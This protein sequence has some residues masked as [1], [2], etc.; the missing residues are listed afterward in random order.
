[1]NIAPQLERTQPMNAAQRE[2]VAHTEGPLLVIAGPGSGKTRS[3]ILRT[4]NILLLEKAKPSEIVLCTYTEKAANELRNRF[5]ALAK[6][7]NFAE[8]ISEL[9]VGT[10]H[11]ICNQLIAEHRHHT[12]LGNDYQQMDQFE[13]RL[14]IFEHLERMSGRDAL[15][16]FEKKWGS[17]WSIA[18][19]LQEYFD[20]FMEELIDIR[21]LLSSS[22]PFLYYLAKAYNAY[23]TFLIRENRVSFA[24]SQRT[25]YDL[26]NNP[27]IAPKIMQKIQY[28][29]VDEYQDTNYIQEQII[30][31]L[32]SA[33]D[34][35]CVIGDE[36]QSLYRF[37]GAT[38]RNILD[39]TDKSPHCATLPLFTNY[40]SHAKIVHRYDQWMA[41]GNWKSAPNEPI[42]RTEKRIIPRPDTTYIDYPAVISIL[43]EKVEDEAQQFAKLV[44]FLYEQ[45]II[46][47]YSQVALLLW[48]VKTEYSGVYIEALHNQNIPVFCPRARMYFKQ[49]EISLLIGCFAFL[50]NYKGD[51]EDNSLLNERFSQFIKKDCLKLLYA[52]TDNYAP[53]HPLLLT[54]QEIR[55][56]ILQQAEDDASPSISLEDCFYQLLATEPFITNGHNGAEHDKE[57]NNGY[58]EHIMHSRSIFSKFLHTFQ[59]AYHHI[60]LN[61]ETI[62][63]IRTDFFTIFLQFLEDSGINEY[64]DKEQPFLQG[65]VQIMTIHQAKGLEFPIVVVGSLGERQSGAH[66][67][68]R[69][70][71]TFYRRKPEPEARI[72]GFDIMRLYYVAFSRAEKLLVLTGN[73]AKPPKSSF[74]T[75][76][77]GLPQWPYIQY[78]L[79]TIS[80]S[81]IKEQTLIKGRYSFTGHIQMYETCPRQYE[82]YQEYKFHPSKQKETFL[83]LLVHQT[84][85]EL[86][87]QAIAGKLAS[88]NEQKIWSILEQV[89]KYLLYTRKAPTDPMLPEKAF[90]QIH[91]YFKQNSREIQ[92][93]IETEVPISIEKDGYILTGRID[94]LMKRNNQL[95]LLDFKVGPRPKPDDERLIDYEATIMHLCSR[96]RKTLSTTA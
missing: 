3:L 66:K 25:A 56:Q 35:V 62:N 73:R 88:L 10:I 75:M 29:C 52:Y 28:M 59:N 61:S 31:K 81:K 53:P 45:K 8:D 32:A 95:H 1:M 91:N 4:M 77:N 16:E 7:L 17:R 47:D 85:E 21:T 83:G 90:T 18:K 64:E 69:D 19:R 51:I 96:T 6:E 40:R 55:A 9:H 12:K 63:K 68:D 24:A 23:G 37:R 72:P 11:S 33:K 46:S 93:V 41:S 74:Q 30:L 38:V 26:L 84:I 27:E 92:Q 79:L 80:P 20:K 48:S 70:L 94:L 2:I 42:F 15:Y 82:Y 87:R 49:E 5:M 43:G 58:E 67:I 34:N 44:S 13:Q 22:Q 89:Y 86:H 78:E 54:L 50:L 60:A 14:F 65:H 36:D 57:G 71:H 76:L 39:F